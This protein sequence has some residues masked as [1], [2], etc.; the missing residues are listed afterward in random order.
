LKVLLFSIIVLFLCVSS[1]SAHYLTYGGLA[2]DLNISQNYSPFSSFIDDDWLVNLPTILQRPD[3][4]IKE[5]KLS[6]KAKF[7]SAAPEHSPV[8]DTDGD[9]WYLKLHVVYDYDNPDT[10]PV[11]ANPSFTKPNAH[12]GS[13]PAAAVPEP[14]TM[15]LLAPAAWIFRKRK[16]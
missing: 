4:R 6:I 10:Y 2:D 16:K 3:A 13:V 5:L 1:A 14:A 11:P 15:L 12:G 8:I 7:H 9:D